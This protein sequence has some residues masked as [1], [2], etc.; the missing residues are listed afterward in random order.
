MTATRRTAASAFFQRSVDI[1]A[2]RGETWGQ[3]A[4][5]AGEEC[6]QQREAHHAPT[7]RDLVGQG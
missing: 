5:E 6:E 3:S 7:D 4:K 1:G 2:Q